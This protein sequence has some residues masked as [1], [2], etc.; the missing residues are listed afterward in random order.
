MTFKQEITLTLTQKDDITIM[1]LGSKKAIKDMEEL[2][3]F[4]KG[5][6]VGKKNPDR[7][8]EYHEHN[9]AETISEMKEFNKKLEA[10][11]NNFLID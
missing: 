2:Q 11:D 1:L 3:A 5:F 10:G 7:F 9:L 4:L 6:L 8:V